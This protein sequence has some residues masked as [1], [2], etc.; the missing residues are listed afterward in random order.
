MNEKQLNNIRINSLISIYLAES[1]H[2]GGVL[3][4][5]DII[6]YLFFSEMNYDKNDFSKINRDRFILS[7]GHCAPALYA[8]AAEVGIIKKSDLK[9]LRKLN[10]KLQGHT[11]RL[12]TPWV[13]ASTGSLGQGFSFAT[14]EAKGLKIQGLNNRVFT[15]LG[16][17]ELQEGEVWEAAMFASHHGLNNLCV[18][19]DYNK[20]QSDDFNK[21]IIGLEP[22]GD[23]W[24]SFNWNVIEID[25]H[26]QNE[27]KNAFNSFNN[28]TNGPFVIIANTIKGKGVSFM[29]GLPSWHGSLKLSYEDLLEAVIELGETEKYI[30]EFINE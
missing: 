14:G 21:N 2:P 6:S 26:N 29:E 10:N 9:G 30:E 13:E 7:K 17:G 16:D 1:G 8:V 28:F 11:H 22:L 20:M 4:S 18:I 24:K 5:I 25:G 27:I 3:S 15:M 23:K 19:I 12:T